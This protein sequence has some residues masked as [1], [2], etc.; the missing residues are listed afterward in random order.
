MATKT[1]QWRERQNH[2]RAIREAER[3]AARRRRNLLTSAVVVVVLLLAVGIGIGVSAARSGT[4]GPALQPRDAVTTGSPVAVGGMMIGNPTAPV[5]MDAY[6]D[7]NCPICGQLEKADGTTITKLIHDG[8]LRVRYHMM[9]FIDDHNGGTYS[10]RSADAFADADTYGSADQAL[11]LH[12]ALYANQPDE[13]SATGLPNSKILELAGNAGVTAQQFVDAVSKN[14]FK[15]W[16][17]TVADDASKA[18]VTGTPTIYLNE[19]PVSLQSLANASG[20]FDPGL[21]TQQINQA[22]G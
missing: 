20:Q 1:Q 11:A 3:Q 4:S 16:V 17:S 22:K 6:E 9:P 8:T 18:G 13:S 5:L 21:L 15:N 14:T 19:K 2:A 7:F 12:T 10:H